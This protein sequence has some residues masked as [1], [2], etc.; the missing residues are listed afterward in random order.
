MKKLCSRSLQAIVTILMLF[1]ISACDLFQPP[2]ETVP[3]ESTEVESNPTEPSEVVIA[4]KIK[5]FDD[6]NVD[7][8]GEDLVNGPQE[9]VYVL[10]DYVN[11]VAAPN[12]VY[13]L[14]SESEGVSFGQVK[15]N[16]VPV[17]V[18]TVGEKTFVLK[19]SND[20]GLLFE[21]NG[22]INVTDSSVYYIENGGFETGD[23]T[24][25]TASENIG[26]VVADNEEYFTFLDPVPTTNHIGDYYLDGFNQAND[27]TSE[28]NIGTLTSSTFVV[29][30]S[31]WVSFQLGGGDQ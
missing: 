30:G 13:E 11:N 26:F 17:T 10:S 5:D 29:G 27:F 19:V 12:T 6:R 8:M 1:A 24:G 3:T 15:N 21:V 25:W 31:R 23:L 4:E 16:K 20:S 2:V 22:K 7:L 14:S 28:S 9:V 18:S